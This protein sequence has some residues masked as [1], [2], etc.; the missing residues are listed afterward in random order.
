MNPN[1]PP[2]HLNEEINARSKILTIFVIFLFAVLLVRLFS[3]QIISGSY[4]ESLSR[5]NRIRMVSIHAPRGK[6]MDRG[7]VVLVENRP[8]YNVMMMP[9][10]VPNIGTISQDLARILEQT[11]TEIEDRISDSKTRP[12]DQVFLARDIT[13]NQVARIE[14][15]I[16]NLPGISIDVTPE[17]DYVFKDLAPHVIGFLGEISRRELNVHGT[18][19]YQRGDL[20]G[21][22][23]VE[24]ACEK[25]LRGKKGARV[26]EVDALGRKI[27]VIDERLPVVGETVVLTID[28]ELQTIAKLA[29]AGRAGAVLAIVP[30]TGEVLV[31]VSS[32]SFDPSMFLSPMAPEAW[33]Q[34][35]SDPLHPLENRAI[36]GL[37]PPGSVYKPVV[38]LTAFS[39]RIVDPKKEINCPGHYVLGTQTYRC[40]KPEGH[41]ALA[42]LEAMSQSCD[43][44][45]YILGEKLGIDRM[46]ETSRYVGFGRPT[47]ID[48]GDE[49]SGVVPSPE[50]KRARFGKSWLPGETIISAIGQGYTLVTPVQVAKIMSALVNG[51]R[52]YTPKILASTPVKLEMVLDVSPADLDLIKEGLRSVVEGERGTARG[53]RDPMF[54]IGGKTGT[55]QVVSGYASRLPDQADIP[56]RYRDHAWFFGFSPVNNPEILV[57]AVVE[58]GGSGS[59]IAAPI[60][61][62]VIKGYY[63][64]KGTSGEQV[65]E[66]NGKY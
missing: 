27:R 12:Y 16:F 11:E 61:R 15:E 1:L 54:S 9:E 63:F 3:M 19:D 45:F 24:L 47:G 52:L 32:P 28:K 14:S 30:S 18:K 46:A 40:W 35:T 8:A 10:D 64:L 43:V 23:G 56:Y 7:G 50:W 38:A 6:V 34:I 5:N 44:Y 39:A 25:I 36:R 60:V 53:I 13:F 33:D 17:R 42:F 49:A 41:G 31:M 20:I 26:F 59:S 65:R 58:H 48:F 29:M 22:S 4:Y 55:A 2:P 57:V 37:Y 51:G 62:D 66:D 21:K